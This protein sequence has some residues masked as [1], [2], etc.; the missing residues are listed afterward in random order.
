[1]WV[2]FKKRWWN[3]PS[4]HEKFQPHTEYVRLNIFVRQIHRLFVCF[5]IL[6]THTRTSVGLRQRSVILYQNPHRLWFFLEWVKKQQSHF[7]SFHIIIFIS[8]IYFWYLQHA[9]LFYSKTTTL[10]SYTS[11]SIS[12]VCRTPPLHLH[13]NGG[14][15]GSSDAFRRNFCVYKRANSEREY[16]K[17]KHKTLKSQIPN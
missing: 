14:V 5:P 9:L 10:L 8:I 16:T 1:M 4:A 2:L 12:G 6:Y 13:F 7:H 3:F 17:D 11:L 15:G